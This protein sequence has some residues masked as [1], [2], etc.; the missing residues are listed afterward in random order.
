MLRGLTVSTIVHGTV[1]AMAVLSWPHKKSDCDRMIERLQKEEPGLAPVD[2]LMRIPQCASAIDVPVDFVEIGLVTDIAPVQKAEEPEEQEEAVPE[3]VEE[4]PEPPPEEESS[5]EEEEV[6]IPDEQAE[7]EPPP[8]KEEPKKEE[9]PPKKEEP[10]LIE[11]QKPKASDDLDFLN[12]FEDILK[13]K[14][15]D[16]QR[17]PREEAPPK[18]DKPVLRDAQETR[19]G[20]GERRGNTASLQ[21]A[22]RR[23]IEVCWRGVADLPKEDQIDVQMRVSLNRDGTLAGNVELVSPSRR[24]VGR[25]GIAVDVALRAVRKCAPYQL[26]EDDYELWKDINVTISPTQP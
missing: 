1:I 2:I 11:K 14:A 21:A 12:D 13:D 7:P 23:Q 18:I 24:P 16:E 6:V 10:K 25:S 22:M 9:P 8:E 4:T 17:R 15:K 20:A 19:P 5:P 3:E 26:P